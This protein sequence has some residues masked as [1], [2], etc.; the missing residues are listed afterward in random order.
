MK[1]KRQNL[2]FTKQRLD[3]AACRGEQSDGGTDLRAQI[4][5]SVVGSPA[6]SPPAPVAECSGTLAPSPAAAPATWWH[7]TRSADATV[8]IVK[9]KKK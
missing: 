1:R 5:A 3:G 7:H 6:L 4:A 2:C 9:K 8:P